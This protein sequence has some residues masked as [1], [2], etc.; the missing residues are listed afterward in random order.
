MNLPPAPRTPQFLRTIKLLARPLEYMEDYGK[1]YGDFFRVGK[2]SSL[3][4]V[5]NPEAIQ[6]IFTAAP[7]QFEIGRGNGMLSFLLGEYSMLMLDGKR[8]Q[9]QRR[10]IM[11]PFH[12]DRLRTYAGLI[13]NV[14]KQ[15]T[16]EWKIGEPFVVRSSMQEITLRV[17]LK[18]VF[19]LDEGERFDQIRK[20]VS[21]LLD[22]L[23]TPMSAT[24]IFFPSL[25]KD[26]GS[27]SPWGRFIRLRQQIEQLIYAEISDRRDQGDFSGNDILTL[28]MLARDEEGQPMTDQELHDELMTLLVAGHETTASAL[29]WALYWIHHLP[30]VH[31]KLSH[32]LNTFSDNATDPSE[33]SRLPYLSAVCSETLRIYPVA[34]TTFVRIL[35]APMELMGYKFTPGTGLMP[36]V[37][38]V[39]QREGYL[40]R[41]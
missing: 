29:A 14:T 41:A 39:H 9:R 12:G 19:G 21:S 24:M 37:Y 16:A 17:I 40:S 3:V 5:N 23:G 22:S 27:L 4:Y 26:F 25:Q 28:L 20:L 30:E 8:H 18:A 38:L 6:E 10:L 31:D 1:L 36:C 35:K 13:C 15:V 34:A 33:I 32:E 11:P 7:E 2:N